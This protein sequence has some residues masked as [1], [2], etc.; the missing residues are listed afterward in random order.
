MCGFGKNVKYHCDPKYSQGICTT[1]FLSLKP[2][3]IKLAWWQLLPFQEKTQKSDLQKLVV[4]VVVF[5]FQLY[6][7]FGLYQNCHVPE[8]MMR[9]YICGISNYS[10]RKLHS[11]PSLCARKSYNFLLERERVRVCDA[12]EKRKSLWQCQ[13]AITT[14]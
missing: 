1:S 10:K 4:V 5:L 9:N 2:K 7:L 6:L 11:D 14:K 3:Y 13:Q 8:S 12:F